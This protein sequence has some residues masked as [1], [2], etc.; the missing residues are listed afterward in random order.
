MANEKSLKESLLA[1]SPFLIKVVEILLGLT[2]MGL[3]VSPYSSRLHTSTGRAGFVYSALSGAI[4]INFLIIASHFLQQRIPK[5]PCLVVSCW[6]G[7]MLA[8]A[9]MVIFSDW[10]ALQFAVQIRPSK[11]RMDLMIS[12]AITTALTSMTYIT[13]FVLTFKYG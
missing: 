8:I 2:S 4:L 10:R 12:S 5:K 1:A 3:I 6:Y 11:Y 7:A 9:A 13:D